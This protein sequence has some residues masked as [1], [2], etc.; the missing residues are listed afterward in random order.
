[1]EYEKY[2]ELTERTGWRVTDLDWGRFAEDAAAGLVGD[3]ERDSLLG[4]AVIEYGVPHYGEVW[5]RVRSLR[6]DWELWQFTTLWTGEEHRHSYSLKKA[7]EL[8]GITSQIQQDLDAVVRFPFAAEQKASCPDDCYSTVPGM[9]AYAMIQELATNKFYTY[10]A[11]RSASPALRELFSLIGADEMRH[12][13]FFR[14]ALRERW[15]ASTDKAW[16]SDQVFRAAQ[17]FKMPHL[18]Y[19]LQEPFFEGGDWVVS[20][21][22]KIQLARCFSFDLELLGRLA[23]AHP[24]TPL[25]PAA[26]RELGANGT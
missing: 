6:D 24:T 8:L 2:Y 5:S 4:T 18:I 19:K 10:A 12:H 11:K 1:M 21:E 13:V 3:F 22:L 26:A 15:T 23:V 25:P 9:L 16:F 14:D 20:T 7:C 17:S